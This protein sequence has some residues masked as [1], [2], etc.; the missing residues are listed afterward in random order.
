[1]G[2]PELPWPLEHS[3]DFALQHVRINRS[4]LLKRRETRTSD[5]IRA[6]LSRKSNF[7]LQGPSTTGRPTCRTPILLRVQRS[8]TDY[9]NGP[10]LRRAV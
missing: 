5:T 4:R 9:G 6:K 10:I 7:A 3:P 2:C 8:D 1:M